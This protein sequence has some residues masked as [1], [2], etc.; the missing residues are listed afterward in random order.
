MQKK[1]NRSL[2]VT[3]AIVLAMLAT[4][5]TACGSIREGMETWESVRER[6]S[7]A[8]NDAQDQNDSQEEAEGESLSEKEES[9]FH[10]VPY[11]RDDAGQ[12]AWVEDNCLY[13][14]WSGRLC[15][16]DLLNG[17][18]TVLFDTGS[19]QK[20]A[21]FIREGQ[22]YFL[23]DS[24]ASSLS[25]ED[26]RLYRIGTDGS[27]LTLLEDELG[28]QHE[29]GCTR[30]ELECYEDILYLVDGG[31]LYDR[32][33]NLYFRLEKDG[34]V[35]PVEE[36]ET[37]YGTLPAG[38]EACSLGE[39]PSLPYQMRNYGYLFLQFKPK[40]EVSGAICVYEPRTGALERLAIEPDEIETGS[41]FLTNDSLCYCEKDRE[42]YGV[43]WYRLSLDNL[44]Y[45]RKWMLFKSAGYMRKFFWDQ[46]GCLFLEYYDSWRLYRADWGDITPREISWSKAQVFEDGA[47]IFADRQFAFYWDG[48]AI[49]YNGFGKNYWGETNDAGNC[50]IREN[51]NGKEESASGKM[52]L[53]CTYGDREEGEHPEDICML[54]TESIKLSRYPDGSGSLQEGSISREKIIFNIPQEDEELYGKGAE[55][56]NAYLEKVYEEDKEWLLGLMEW[57]GTNTY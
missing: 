15:R 24:P 32:Q 46:D 52:R 19:E 17:E 51:L 13:S 16:Y 8:G 21:F 12:D 28:G 49:Y 11:F 55:V 35:T 2:C 22:I 57:T 47:R 25:G 30:Y 29:W 34:S 40:E 53:F 36:S 14:Y 50:V 44:H 10:A 31:S 41:L 38:Y 1:K 43:Q 37:L 42:S 54:Q 3:A 27:N 45:S 5:L 18:E 39:M 20:G 56:I 4:G 26:T 7:E 6:I 33:E 48:K 9:P 23:V